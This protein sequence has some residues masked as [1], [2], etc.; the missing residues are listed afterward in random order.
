MEYMRSLY[1][2]FTDDEDD[3]EARCMVAFCL[4]IGGPFIAA[5]HGT[6]SRDEVVARAL[7]RL[8]D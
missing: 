5:D 6:L 1:R 3:V 8:E 4:W 7:K 2:A